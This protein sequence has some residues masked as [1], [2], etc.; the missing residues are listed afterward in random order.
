M[1]FNFE[2]GYMCCAEQVDAEGNCPN[3]AE[4]SDCKV[5]Y[6]GIWTCTDH[7][8]A[9]RG[10]ADQI[11]FVEGEKGSKFK[12]TYYLFLIRHVII[13]IVYS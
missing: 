11:S 3:G 9:V 7:P 12:I 5:R 6:N 2:S 1:P 8:T 13:S 10:G 4:S